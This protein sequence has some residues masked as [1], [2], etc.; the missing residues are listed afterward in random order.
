MINPRL[1]ID[2]AKIAVNASL[3]IDK[4]KR[5]GIDVVPVTKVF[6]GHPKIAATL[7]ESGA[8][9]LADSRIENIERM[10]RAGITIPMMLIRSPM[11]SQVNRVVLNCEISLNTELFTISALSKAAKK[12]GYCHGVIVMVELGDLREGVMPDL[13]SNTIRQT[14]AL[15]NIDLKGIGANLACRYGIAPEQENM[16]FL[17]KLVIEVENQFG[18]RLQVISGGNSANLLWAFNL[19]QRSCVTQLRLGES[20]F[21]GVEA[22]NK[23]PIAGANTDAISLVAEVIESSNKPSKPWGRRYQNAFGETPEAVDRGQVDQALLA[24]GRQDVNPSGVI[25]PKGITIL[26]SSSDHMVVESAEAP[27]KIGQ[28]I[29]F[30]LDYVGLLSAMTS[31]YVRKYFY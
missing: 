12:A 14:L 1:E 27:L 6:M 26:A 15:S 31:P 20:I 30:K 29:R 10:R 4:L 9:M 19:D 16:A 25:P 17:A 22:L 28:E 21:F 23:R 7:I 18:I 5:H 11:L 3:L 2:C 24:L 13:L 8:T